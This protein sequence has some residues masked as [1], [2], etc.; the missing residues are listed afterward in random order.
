MVYKQLL[1]ELHEKLTDHMMHHRKLLHSIW[2]KGSFTTEAVVDYFTDIDYVMVLHDLGDVPKIEAVLTDAFDCVMFEGQYY[3]TEYV[4]RAVI[5]Y[6][7]DVCFIDILMTDTPLFKANY[8]HQDGLTFVYGPR[9]YSEVMC[10]KKTYVY[11]KK[12]YESNNSVWFMLFLALRKVGRGDFL[13][14]R[15]LILEVIQELLIIEMI[16]RDNKKGTD[17]HRFGDE[18][19]F[20][21]AI[22]LSDLMSGYKKD[23]IDCIMTVGEVYHKLILQIDSDSKTPIK[24]LR[25]YGENSKKYV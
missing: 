18:E 4:I 2:L 24:S 23:L 20:V 15:H 3:K 10:E 16:N 9:D 11:E 12:H 6:Q 8:W 1:S 5:E 14:A 21:E 19:N 17:R 13:I 22:E 7:G 25:L